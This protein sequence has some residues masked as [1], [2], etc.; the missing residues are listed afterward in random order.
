[1]PWVIR[2]PYQGLTLSGPVLELGI[3]ITRLAGLTGE[4]TIIPN[5]LVLEV[6][7]HTRRQTTVSI[8]VPLAPDRE[9]DRARR[10]FEQMV[11]EMEDQA[12]GLKLSG[13]TDIQMGV[14]MWNLTAPTR[15][16]TAYTTSFILR[17]AVAQKHIPRKIVLSWCDERKRMDKPKYALNDT[18]ELKKAHPCGSHTWVIWRTGMDFGLKCLGCG[19]RI[20]MPRKDFERAV[21]KHWPLSAE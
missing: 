18:V 15:Y 2:L 7:N 19:H 9:P 4:E 6:Q 10:A 3:R 20:M 5:R 13:V 21:K 17:E 1:M 16:D 11:V 8:N 12:S 14:V